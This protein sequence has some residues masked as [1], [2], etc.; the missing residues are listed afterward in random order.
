M[1]FQFQWL[2]HKTETHRFFQVMDVHRRLDDELMNYDD[3][4]EV[5][6][7]LEKEFDDDQHTKPV[8]WFAEW[9]KV[10]NDDGQ[11]IFQHYQTFTSLSQSFPS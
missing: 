6:N 2:Q 7:H 3:V 1:I 8:I 11:L 9:Q 4:D 10:Q 5:I